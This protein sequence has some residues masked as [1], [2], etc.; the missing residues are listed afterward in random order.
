MQKQEEGV[1]GAIRL[2]EG[3]RVDS[4][5]ETRAVCTRSYITSGCEQ[6]RVWSDRQLPDS[7][8]KDVSVVLPG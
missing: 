1:K 7:T 5:A 6:G 4:E 2:N 8:N 3:V